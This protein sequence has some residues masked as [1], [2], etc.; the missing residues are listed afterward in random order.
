VLPVA[1][2]GTQLRIMI[3]RRLMTICVRR[4]AD[5][6]AGAFSLAVAM[7]CVFVYF[8]VV[9]TDWI[10]HEEPVNSTYYFEDYLKGK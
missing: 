6:G 4:L 3:D 2:G 8:V 1:A 7:T 9:A 5:A 10:L